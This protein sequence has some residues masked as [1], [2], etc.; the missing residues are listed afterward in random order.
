MSCINNNK[1]TSK[2]NIIMHYYTIWIMTLFI[3]FVVNNN[4]NNNNQNCFVFV[5]STNINKSS[6][7]VPENNTLKIAIMSPRIKKSTGKPVGWSTT[8]LV[9][10]LLAIDVINN[11]T[12]KIF[13][14]ILP[15]TTIVY[16]FYDSLQD[17]ETVAKIAPEFL[18]KAFKGKGSD[19]VLGAG[20]S[21]S[22][23][24]L[25]SILQHFNIPQVS[26]S[27]TSGYLSVLQ[28]YPYFSRIIPT[29]GILTDAMIQF[30]TYT[31]GWESG[32]IICGSDAYSIYGGTS[33]NNAAKI[34]NLDIK[35]FQV[36]PSD[37]ENMD[38]QVKY[39]VRTGARLFFYFGRSTDIITFLKSMYNSLLARGDI[40]EGFSIIY[41]DGISDALLANL[42]SNFLASNEQHIFDTMINGSYSTTF[43]IRGGN[44]SKL[45]R[46]LYA[47]EI[48]TNSNCY[49]KHITR[50]SCS[51]CL[52][53][54]MNPV[55]NSSIFHVENQLNTGTKI[56]VA[57]SNSSGIGYY[58][59]FSFDSVIMIAHAYDHIIKKKH[60][61]KFTGTEFMNVVSDPSF[62]FNGATGKVKLD[63][64]GDRIQ[65]G[66]S[67]DIWSLKVS[68]NNNKNRYYVGTL[69]ISG[70]SG[71]GKNFEFCTFSFTK[72]LHGDGNLCM[73]QFSFNTKLNIRPDPKDR[74]LSKINLGIITSTFKGIKPYSLDV[75]GNQRTL[76]ILVAIDEMNNKSNPLRKLYFNSTP[77]IVYKWENS[78]RSSSYAAVAGSNYL[79]S[80]FPGEGTD[81]VIGAFS[82]GPS[83]S[84][85][86]I[87]SSII[88]FPK[89]LTTQMASNTSFL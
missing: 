3:F 56:C 38:P 84:L 22:S 36:F 68:P 6:I 14:D 5:S 89:Y 15:N 72:D 45:F 78:R 53:H 19:I 80:S 44:A 7:I 47:N 46:Q 63:K 35:A 59:Q 74:T 26:P 58:P 23:M 51:N 73:P 17:I 40:E 12:D 85:Q 86:T 37:T 41:G 32:A 21:G 76:A 61:L 11:K 20:T 71:T 75:T 39:A 62:S 43:S 24:V 88:I 49:G 30:A 50:T 18:D 10:T 34:H 64:N 66:L 82:S 83:M 60:K 77:P 16:E 25:H 9:A 42:K 27:A 65:E 29:D 67:I 57:P 31:I 4:N 87:V 54:R 2:I 33:L 28:D 1:I 69:D 79:G 8:S 81:V 13:D 70:T 55:S 48:K 52:K